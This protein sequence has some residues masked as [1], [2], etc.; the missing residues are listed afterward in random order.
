[1]EMGIIFIMLMQ[2]HLKKIYRKTV[3]QCRVHCTIYYS[4]IFIPTSF[5]LAAIHNVYGLY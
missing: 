3:E 1:M 2:F 5:V 4:N